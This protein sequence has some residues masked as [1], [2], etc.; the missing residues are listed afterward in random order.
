MDATYNDVNTWRHSSVLDAFSNGAKWKSYD[1]K[2]KKD[3]EALFIDPLFYTASCL[4][5][6]DLH[7]SR[8]D[9]PTGLI[10][11]ANSDGV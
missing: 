7:M 1:I 2:T 8:D 9:A 5:I 3:L 6:V 11:T 10:T 4:Q